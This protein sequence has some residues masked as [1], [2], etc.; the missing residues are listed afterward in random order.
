MAIKDYMVALKEAEVEV[1]KLTTENN[2][3]RMHIETLKKEMDFWISRAAE[4]GGMDFSNGG[5]CGIS[6]NALIRFASGKDNSMDP[7]EYP[8]DEADWGRCERTIQ[9]IPFKD[10]LV[11][12]FYI[13]D[14]NGWKEWEGK[15]IIAVTSRMLELR[16]AE[17]P[18]D[19]K[20]ARPGK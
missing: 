5:L 17:E 8:R 2:I 9:T 3:I 20:D 6:S 1:K 13:S 14:Y 7:E 15:I 12:L 11:K 19:V 4:G 16:K 10:W 18:K